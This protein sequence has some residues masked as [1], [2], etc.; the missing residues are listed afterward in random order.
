MRLLRH[1]G[2]P[3]PPTSKTPQSA[4]LTGTGVSKKYRDLA[5]MPRASVPFWQFVDV[6]AKSPLLGPEMVTR[7]SSRLD[8]ASGK[9][10]REFPKGRAAL[11]ISSRLTVGPRSRSEV[12]PLRVGCP[13]GIPT[14]A[15]HQARTVTAAA[16]L[17]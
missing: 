16:P 8:L 10:H 4:S 5:A 9:D 7:P 1:D 11:A 12:W 15:N 17:R 6:I 13:S 14:V 3:P 2:A